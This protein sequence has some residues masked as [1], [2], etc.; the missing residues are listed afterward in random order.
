MPNYARISQVTDISKIVRDSIYQTL[1]E[2]ALRT[3]YIAD[4]L[5][6]PEYLI[7]VRIYDALWTALGGRHTIDSNNRVTITLEQLTKDVKWA[8]KKPGPTPK[9]LFGAK[10]HDICVW[11]GDSPICVIEVKIFEN[12]YGVFDSDIAR[13]EAV[14]KGK[15]A[16]K[17]GILAFLG[18]WLYLDEEE[19]DKHRVQISER[20][21]NHR[22]S[23]E[24]ISVPEESALW[25]AGSIVVTNES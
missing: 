4:Y 10:R 19:I 17:Y 1:N 25:I 7:G 16:P 3:N 23:L 21:E 12:R 6:P 13:L 2:Y 22:V 8:S 11:K 24:E 18:H 9:I 20:F 15:K 5:R 14:A